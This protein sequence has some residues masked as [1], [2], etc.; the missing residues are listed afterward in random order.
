MN[1]Y[2]K[3]QINVHSDCLHFIKHKQRSNSEWKKVNYV[4]SITSVCQLHFIDVKCE[5]HEC[6]VDENIS[7]PNHIIGFDF[8]QIYFRFAVEKLYRCI[9]IDL[10]CS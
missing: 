4:S 7:M 10:V 1:I 3:Q 8:K 9:S 2:S 5:S 6:G